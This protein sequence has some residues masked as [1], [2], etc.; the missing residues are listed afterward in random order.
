MVKFSDFPDCSNIS[1]YLPTSHFIH[2]VHDYLSKIK[3][4]ESTNC[5]PYN[6]YNIDIVVFDQKN[7]MLFNFV[8][9]AQFCF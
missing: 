7:I 4:Y 5:H 1:L 3:F 2:I 9:I 6:P 8:H